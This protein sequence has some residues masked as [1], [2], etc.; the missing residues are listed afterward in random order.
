M[1][2]KISWV[3]RSLQVVGVA[4]FLMTGPGCD[5]SDPSTDSMDNYFSQNPLENQTREPIQPGILV[6]TPT[7]ATVTFIGQQ[8]NFRVSEGTAPFTWSVALPAVGSVSPVTGSQTIYTVASVSANSVVV[9]DSKG[10]AVSAEI[11]ASPVAMAVTPSTVTLENYGDLAT[12]TVTGGTAP[13][14][15]TVSDAP[16]GKMLNPPV[17]SSTEVYQ[18]LAPGD[19]SITIVDDLGNTAIALVKQP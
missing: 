16:L 4:L 14:T 18:R 10:Q 19:N 6:V 9:H 3:I 12:F 17:D 7:K 1:N 5:T 2:K 13:F 11:T 8:V 15:W